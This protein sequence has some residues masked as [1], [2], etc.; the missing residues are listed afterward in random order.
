[1]KYSDYGLDEV[2]KSQDDGSKQKTWHCLWGD[3]GNEMGGHE[4]T[5][6]F[7][8]CFASF[9][10]CRDCVETA[11]E[12]EHSHRWITADCFKCSTK[13]LKVYSSKD[14]DP[15]NGISL[16]SKCLVWAKETF[17]KQDEF[18]NKEREQMTTEEILQKCTV[19]GNEIRLPND[20]VLDYKSEY[21]PVQ[22]KM[23]KAGGRWIGRDVSAFVFKSDP[24]DILADLQAG[25]TPLKLAVAETKSS[26]A[27]LLPEIGRKL[28]EMR[29]QVAKSEVDQAKYNEFTEQKET[30]VD[31]A[32]MIIESADGSCTL[33]DDGEALTISRP[34]PAIGQII[35]TQ[36]KPSEKLNNKSPKTEMSFFTQLAALLGQ[37]EISLTVKGKDDKLTVMMMPKGATHLEKLKPLILTASAEELDEGFFSEVGS[38]I[39]KISGIVSNADQYEKSLN[40]AIKKT[41]AT[42]DAKPGKSRR[43]KK[44]ATE[45]AIP[46][47]ETTEEQLPIEEV[48]S[49]GQA[50]TDT[51]EQPVAAAEEI[52][53]QEELDRI[54]AQERKEMHDE[55]MERASRFMA[56]RDFTKALEA[57]ES[58][59]QYSDDLE[60]ID[61]SIAS[62]KEEIE[63]TD[64][65]NRLVGKSAEFAGANDWKNAAGALKQAKNFSADPDT[66]DEKIKEYIQ[67][68]I[69]AEMESQEPSYL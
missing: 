6:G 53:N 5:N 38:S 11:D 61:G 7:N 16:C 15:Q 37:A 43:G 9:V 66:L 49:E 67:K 19:H 42:D 63:R 56:A 62:C 31:L 32:P 64:T 18:I 55:L 58:A 59:K 26:V 40:E 4:V 57:F 10:I 20:V 3:E 41:A 34:E 13:E 8:L 54:A 1:M 47:V 44:D 27:E 21:K 50:T 17:T 23:E 25:Q 30:P 46:V 12:L 51:Q 48:A 33:V 2:K 28:E 14:A 29:D 22:K 35:H 65:F 24:T 68:S 36:L 39:E 60:A 69:Q 52:V 45:E